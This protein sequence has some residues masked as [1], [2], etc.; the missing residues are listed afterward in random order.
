MTRRLFQEPEKAKVR[1]LRADVSSEKGSCKVYLG[2]L[3]INR[4]MVIGQK[5]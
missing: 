5:G 2:S 3:K 4:A 1:L